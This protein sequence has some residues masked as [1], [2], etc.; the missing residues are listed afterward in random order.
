MQIF[1]LFSL[2]IRFF[3]NV[4]DL[5]L[6]GL[7]GDQ[8]DSVDPLGVGTMPLFHHPGVNVYIPGIPRQG[9]ITLSVF[10]GTY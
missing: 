2:L 5:S 10:P 6:V 1:L 9:M 3:T 4:S 7:I 8:R